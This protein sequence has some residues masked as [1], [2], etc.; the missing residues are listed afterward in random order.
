VCTLCAWKSRRKSTHKNCA[1][2]ASQREKLAACSSC[3]C[4]SGVISSCGCTPLLPAGHYS[5]GIAYWQPV[6]VINLTLL[7]PSPFSLVCPQVLGVDCPSTGVLMDV[8]FL[9]DSGETT[10]KRNA[11]CVFESVAQTPLR[12]HSNGDDYAGLAMHYLVVREVR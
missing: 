8:S 2:Q 6:A 9:S 1:L 10:T 5:G 4:F 11:I 12:R 7:F 3:V